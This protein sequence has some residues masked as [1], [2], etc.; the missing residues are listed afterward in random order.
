ML[1]RKQ[2]HNITFAKWPARELRVRGAE[3][4]KTLNAVEAVNQDGQAKWPFVANKHRKQTT[5]NCE[6]KKR[7]TSYARKWLISE[8]SLPLIYVVTYL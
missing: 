8:E 2:V 5:I 1:L 4:V 3:S 7:N 6:D